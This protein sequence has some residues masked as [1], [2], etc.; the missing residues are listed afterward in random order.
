MSEPSVRQADVRMRGFRNRTP[1]EEVWDWLEGW[2]RPRGAEEVPV[3]A[4]C[5]RVLAEAITAPESVPPFARAAM[6]GY[7]LRGAETVGADPYNPLE[8]TVTGESLPGRPFPEPLPAGA[9]VRIMT[10]APVPEGADAV[11]PAEYAE[12][13]GSGE[14]TR[15]AV[16]AAVPPRK[17]VGR[18]GED[19]AAGERLLERGRVLR[20][21]DGGLIASLGLDRVRVVAAPGVRV[22]VTGDE[23]AAPGTARG[24]AQIYDANSAIL[25]GL[26]A[27]DGGRMVRTERVGD[28]PKSL[29]RLLTAGGAELVIVTGG[30]SVGAEDHAPRL[31]AEAGELAFHGVAMRPS[32][33]TGL[34]RLGDVPVFLLPGN[35]VSCLA[36]Y[37]LFAGR[38]L[39]LLA[40]RDPRWPH[41]TVRAPLARKIAS[42]VGR[43]D[44]CRVGLG[45][46][47]VEPIALSGASILSSATRADGFVLV[48]ADSEGFAPGTE[49]TVHLYHP[50]NP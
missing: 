15:V 37:E 21:Q 27:R 18:V 30:S 39:R 2:I 1:V 33:P 50:V 19:V 7:A 29:R 4:A 49:V 35:P 24:P 28:D 14:K 31:L 17:H 16:T 48:P 13:T 6:D 45:P 8:L 46:D 5:G 3:A 32:A 26:V 44:Y 12:E 41:R 11:L 23:L 9:A 20:P 25:P 43:M 22:V 42:A 47:G 34:G 40:G 10:G 36:G 38:A